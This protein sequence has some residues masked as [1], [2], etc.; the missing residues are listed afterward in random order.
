[1]NAESKSSAPIRSDWCLAK[2]LDSRRYVWLLSNLIGVWAKCLASHRDAVIPNICGN[3]ENL[4]ISRSLDFDASIDGD[5]ESWHI[6]TNVGAKSLARRQS[7][8]RL[9]EAFSSHQNVWRP[10]NLV[11]AWAKCFAPNR[12]VEILNI[13]GNYVISIFRDFDDSIGGNVE[14]RNWKY[15]KSGVSAEAT[16]RQKCVIAKSC[17]SSKVALQKKRCLDKCGVWA[18][19]KAARSFQ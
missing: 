9:A 15:S 6:L 17:A 10:G 4:D 13:C 3:C 2:Y 16:P 7:I 19:L 11:G 12:S 18:K 14:S 5:V 8:W 1:M